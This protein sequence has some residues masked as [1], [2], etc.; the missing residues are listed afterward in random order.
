MHNILRRQTQQGHSL[1]GDTNEF[2][3]VEIPM[4]YIRGN[5]EKLWLV[6]EVLARDKTWELS[7]TKNMDEK[8]GEMHLK[9]KYAL[10]TENLSK[11]EE[12]ENDITE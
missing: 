11:V 2:F 12:E 8:L 4:R 10:S 1:E 3:K 5:S 9:I 6:E 7:H